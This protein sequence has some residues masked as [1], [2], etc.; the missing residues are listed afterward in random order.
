MK[1]LKLEDLYK[2]KISVIMYFAAN[3]EGYEFLSKRL[4]IR[5]HNYGTRNLYPFLLPRYRLSKS[6]RSALDFGIKISD[7][8][9]NHH[10]QLSLSTY[11][12]VFKYHFF[13]KYSN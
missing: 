13:N 6:K 8:L 5:N 4:I 11:K 9:L 3:N 10:F 7:T 2:F 1:T 12:N